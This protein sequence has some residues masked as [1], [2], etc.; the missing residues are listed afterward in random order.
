MIVKANGYVISTTQEACVKRD[1]CAVMSWNAVHSFYEE[2][3]ESTW[4]SRRRLQDVIK[5]GL[6]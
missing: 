6:T 2:S 5:A 4:K 3:E 1:R